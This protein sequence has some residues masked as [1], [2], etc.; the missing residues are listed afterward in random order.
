MKLD[1][2]YGNML[3]STGTMREEDLIPEFMRF[4]AGVKGEKITSFIPEDLSPETQAAI[5]CWLFG[6]EVEPHTDNTREELSS[7]LN[8]DLFDRFSEIAPE[9]YYFGSH[10]GDGAAYGFW[11]IEEV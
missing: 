7:F 2:Y 1:N 11:R 6:V 10:P 8:E 4:L 5:I 3:V 9:G